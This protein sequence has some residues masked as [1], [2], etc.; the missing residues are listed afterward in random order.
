MLKKSALLFL[1]LSFAWGC[2]KNPLSVSP[3]NSY[4]TANY[5]A[6]LD[7][8]QSVLA[9][10]YS[11]L[12]SVG[13][14]GFELLPKALANCTHTANS[15]YGGDQGWN[16][17]A[18]TNLSV[19]NQYA[20][21]TWQGLYVGVKNCNVLL[22]AADLYT[23]KFAKSGDQP[24]IDYIRGQAYFL[25]A[26]YYFELECFYGEDNVPNPSAADTLGVPILSA[27]PTNLAGTQQ[28][29]SSIRAVWALI[30]S[31]LKQSMS[32]LKGQVWTGNDIGRVTQWSAEGLLGKAYVFTKDWTDA[33]TALLDVINNSGKS[34]M[35]YAQYRDAFIG[36]SANEFNSES[37][38]EINVDQQSNGD[39]G[40]YGGTPNATTINGLIWPPWALGFDGTE[41]A[42]NPL[43]YGNEILHDKNVLRF[44]FN[45]G[46]YNLVTNPDFNGSEPP[47]YTNPK[48]I[49]D[50]AYKQQS[51][52]VRTN[53]TCDPRLFVNAL[54]PWVDSVKYDG[55]NW[56]PVSKPNFY[57]G[58]Y[59]K[60]GWSIRKYS[61][62]FN[63][64][65]NTGPA[66]AC[67]IYLLRLADIYLL[68]A[69]ACMNSGDNNTAL[70]YI[71]KVHRRAYGYPV[72]V[73]SPVDYLSLTDTTSAIDDP[74]LGHNPL[75]YERWAELF[76]EGQWWFDICRWHLGPSEAAYY[77]T[78]LNVS[79]PLSFPD[80][81]YAW[82]IPNSEIN[83]NPKIVQNPGY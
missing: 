35:S 18:A 73:P 21:D 42:A 49:M 28:P 43:G 70:E 6:T 34:L 64:I 68:Y 15:A 40:V 72:D 37:L 44:G 31:D 3:T 4:S 71:N 66:D 10:C 17:M 27:L 59:D 46:T 33:K 61:P 32:L 51:L 29:R 57:A 50:P 76:N 38:F 83:T 56:F 82:P 16:E 60:Y 8:L 22:A 23:A 9:S 39:Y 2:T 1:A 7:G 11:N 24:T 77:G 48:M 47:S 75:Y 81:S 54:Q 45:I 41:G 67:N 53:Q 78:A 36:I 63:N 80:K 79:G 12:R 13:L 30:E 62:I 58:Q 69:E 26:F 5:P 20:S 74:V 65:N 19:T 14:Y 25:R 52:L 55:Q